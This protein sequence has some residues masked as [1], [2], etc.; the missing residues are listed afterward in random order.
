M[1][2]KKNFFRQKYMNM[3]SKLPAMKIAINSNLFPFIPFIYFIIIQRKIKISPYAKN[4]GYKEFIV[5]EKLVLTFP[6]FLRNS[7]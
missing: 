1:K 4:V 6:I 5:V 2:K 7:K 3:L